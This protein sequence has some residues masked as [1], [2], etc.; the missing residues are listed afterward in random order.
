MESVPFNVK[1]VDGGFSEAHGS[2]YV[3]GEHLVLDVEKA[4][5]GH[6]MR[7]SKIHRIDLTDLDTVSYKKGIRKDQVS[8]RTRPISRLARIPGVV[9]GAL[10]IQVKKKHRRV[11]EVLLDRLDLWRV[12]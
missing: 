1:E 10:T 7:K 11:L 6:F 12:D 8:I 9:E 5:L 4:F 2:A 3:D